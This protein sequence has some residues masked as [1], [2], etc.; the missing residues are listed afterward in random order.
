MKPS[1][2]SVASE[3]PPLRPQEDTW[4]PQLPVGSLF[5]GLPSPAHLP[6]LLDSESRALIVEGF[7]LM[8]SYR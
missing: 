6:C 1:H 4:N 3:M 2:P 8:S 5:P 7:F